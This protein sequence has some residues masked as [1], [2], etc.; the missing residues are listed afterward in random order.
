MKKP[1][2]LLS[3]VL[4]ATM[5]VGLL[6]VDP[7][8]QKASAAEGRKTLEV[9]KTLHAP[10]IDGTLDD[11]VWS[12]DQSLDVLVGEGPARASKFGLLWDNQY[13]YVGVKAEDPAPMQ[14]KS[15][16]WFDQD[17]INLF[18]D[19]T[20]H[21]STP[22]AKDDMQAGFV[23]RQDSATPEFH[24]GAALNT[25]AGKDEKD[26]LRSIRKT[27]TGWNLEVAIPW[28]ML[29]FNP[30]LTKQLGFEIGVTDRFGDQE[31]NQR[32]SFWSA[33]QTKSFWNDTSGFGTLVLNDDNPVTNQTNNV[34]LLENFDG[35]PNGALPQNW[36]SDVNAGSNPFTV[37]RDT[38]GNARLVFDGKASGKQ[39][40]VAAPVQW[41]NYTVEADVR[42]ESVLDDGRWASLMFRGSSNGKAPYN[43]MALRQNGKY[44]VAM[45][46]PDNS[47]SVIASG[48]SNPLALNADY[49]MKVRVFDNNVK[50]YI[51]AKDDPNYTLLLDQSFTKDLLQ[52]GKIGFQ[53]DQ[54]KVSFDN[55]KVTR[56]TADRFDLTL[57]A[58]VEALSGPLSVTGSV[59]FSDGL[60][61]TVASDRLKLYSTDESVLKVINNQVYPLRAGSAT[62]KS[63][64]GNAE[65]S[66][67][68]TVTPSATGAKVVKLN[69]TQGYELAT[70]GV[71]VALDT[72]TFQTELSDFTSGTIRGNQLTWSTDSSA[73]TIAGNGITVRQKGVH[74]L[75]AQIDGVTVP[76]LVVAKDAGDAEYVLYEENFDNVSDGTMPQGWTRKEGTTV[77]AAAVRSGAFEINASASPD[78][79]SRVLLPDYLGAFGDYKIEADVTHLAAN[80][81]ARWHSIMFRI[82]NNDF[83]Y[84]QMAVRKDATVTNG[85]EFAERTP[86]NGWS[87][88]DTGSYSEAIDPA[89]MYRYTVKARGNRVQEWIGDKL[90]VDTDNASAYAKGRIGLQ[91]NGSK[92]KVDNIRVTLQQEALPPMPVDRFV[93]VYE[94]ETKIAMAPTVVAEL[95]NADQ[96]AA[97][98][99]S[100]SP[101]TVMLHLNDDLSISDAS[102]SKTIGDVE[103]ILNSLGSR[104]IPAFH[105]RTEQAADKLI[106]LIEAKRIEDAFVVSDNGSLIKRVRT[107][108]PLIRGI[109][110]LSGKSGKALTKDNL[111][112]ILRE[113]TLSG[114][115]IAILPQEAATLDNMAY[116]QQR[117]IVVWA[118]ETAD[119]KGKNVALHTLITAGANGIV[120]DS[121]DAAIQALAVYNN[122]TTLV[123]KPYIIGHRGMPSTSPENTIESNR[124]A[125]EA[126]ADFIEND[127]FVTKDDHLVI[128]HDTVLQNTTNGT[129][130]VED[131]TLEE[132]KRLNA[133]KPYPKGFPDVKIPTL[134]EQI[135]LAREKGGMVYAEIKTSTP[136]AVDV[137]VKLIKEKKAEDIVNIMSFDSNQLKRFAQQMPEVPLGLL[138]GSPGSDTDANI[139]KTLRDTLRTVQNQNVTFNAGYY[140]LGQK[141][142]EAAKHRGV[143]ISP[144]TINDKVDFTSFFLRGPFGITTDY[145][146][147]ASDWNASLR[148]DKEIY[149]LSVGENATLTANAE[150]FKRVKEPVKPEL[151]WLDGKELFETD[152]STVKAKKPGTA[153]VLLRYTTVIG[154]T[155]K[156]DLYTQPVT[157][158]IKSPDGGNTGGDNGSDN[159]SENGGNNSGNNGSTG[160][161]APGG[162]TPSKP[163]DKAGVVSAADGKVGS[164]ALKK[165]FEV[166]SNVEVHFTGSTLAVPADAWTD[167][168]RAKGGTLIVASDSAAYHFPA[169]AWQP[170]QWAAQLGSPASPVT[171]RFTMKVLDGSEAAS[172]ASAVK[173]AG[174][175]Q[176]ADA[177]HFEVEAVN[178]DGKSVPVTFGSAYITRDMTVK[179][180]VDPAKATGVQLFPETQQ[181]RFVPTV[182]TTA[183]GNTTAAMKRNGNSVYTIVQND[184]SFSDMSGHWAKADVELLANKFVVDGVSDSRFDPERGITRAEFAALL[185]RALALNPASGSSEFRDVNAGSWYAKDVAAASAA[186]LIGGFEDGTFR[187]D[188][189]VKREEQAAMLVRALSYAGID[190][191]VTKSKQDDILGRYRDRDGIAWAQ[192]E[193][194]AAVNAGLMNGMTADT[195]DAQSHATRAQSATM[196][197]RFLSKAAFI[198]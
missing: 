72:W 187:P 83:P 151:V 116:L 144:W 127:M 18:F 24:F 169:S 98:N 70:T 149:V 153:H 53:V 62:I 11:S 145:A 86:A 139:N 22:Y 142:M 40:R 16:N 177:V 91:A 159:G 193:L 63:V 57:P 120:T 17:N 184:K 45:R 186:G 182:F 88:M 132:L 44:E 42:F 140:N 82:Q 99:N 46:K 133:N 160:S 48:A 170:E 119:S 176:I 114:S 105:I 43:Q 150:S 35:I 6:P 8:T 131:F 134:D 138:V 64:F 178:A 31:A 102:G 37:Q 146:Y 194:S 33:F 92:M 172:A 161:G 106:Q 3:I 130:N 93:K 189:P 4:S 152:G 41:D 168:A 167:E 103:T 36:I 198:N 104:V 158:E 128:I 196:L 155:N 190:I 19:P 69:H 181:V 171:L 97:W 59:Y 135:D 29:N 23:F 60:T 195:L 126:G 143:I 21:R 163:D 136:R 125:L 38:Y 183:N 164:E 87:V 20:L 74:Q 7:F 77:A 85:V 123:R 12:I 30:V 96:A 90:L 47:W 76:L 80:D 52:R 32:T 54:S 162:S 67:T 121:P 79:P 173:A 61:E 129:G 75:S 55:L 154:E 34:L 56:I 110:D 175:Q 1:S 94:P 50:E 65:A 28:D 25:H 2:K 100:P 68:I 26:I 101:A 117:T 27:D 109:L 58:T 89:K 148:A 15:G 115:K 174:G 81:N 147:Y 108:A 10:I 39:A 14:D 191:S 5:L 179:G 9:R 113:T 112:D 78:N 13:L 51:K 141:F 180:A 185:V 84:Y 124:L 73:V 156:Y 192:A 188:Q 118:K 66:R 137:L 157:L 107:A 165:A 197:K 49:T 111:L 122:A 95:A 71:P 166:S